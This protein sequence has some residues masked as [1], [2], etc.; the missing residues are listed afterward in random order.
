MQF[1]HV[2]AN[3]VQD[4]YFSSRDMCKF[5]GITPDI[6]GK[7][8]GSVFVE[9]GRFDLGL[10]LKRN[11][12]YQLLGFV[13]KV[14]TQGQAVPAANVWG[15]EDKV[16]ITGA[17]SGNGEESSVAD[18]VSA[19]W[20]YSGRAVQLLQEYK[21]FFPQLFAGLARLQHKPKYTISELLG[22]GGLALVEQIVSWQQGEA[23]FHMPRTLLSTQTLSK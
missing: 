17:A 12:Q 9:P 14:E 8:V 6:L 20:E 23:F 22:N 4:E 21:Q 16:Q 1:G 15:V 5:C 2:I 10:N 13:R 18:N 11:G 19:L 7:I 3:A